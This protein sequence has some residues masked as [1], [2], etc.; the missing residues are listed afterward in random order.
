MFKGFYNLTSGMLTQ[1]RRLDVVANNMTNIGTAGY[2]S[3]RFT[4]STFQDVLYTRIGN[5]DRDVHAPLGNQSYILAPSQSYTDF[6]QGTLEETG[7]TLDFAIEGEGFFAIQTEDGTAYTRSG[8]FSL[9]EQGYLC[10][11]GQGRVLDADGQP[12]LM[13]TDKI[14]ADAYGSLYTEQGGFIARLGVFTFADT[15]ALER[16]DQG[17]FVSAAAP[18]AEGGPVHWRM[19]ERSNVDL[20]LQMTEMMASQRLLQSG[21]QVTKI[22]DQVMSKITNDIGQL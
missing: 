7:L 16:N 1:E 21:A 22:Y 6:G 15:A 12:I 13:G 11:P 19:L 18:E 8:S 17:L 20:L 2:K 10:L 4:A 3:D 14:S 5:Q 9:D